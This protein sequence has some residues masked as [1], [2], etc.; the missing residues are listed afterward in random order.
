MEGRLVYMDGLAKVFSL[1][2]DALFPRSCVMCKEEGE[3]LCEVCAK[4]IEIPSWFVHQTEGS[5]CIFSRCSYKE[6]AVQKLLH[7]WKYQGDI[8]A[9]EWWKK[10]I[11][12]G[13]APEVFTHAVF[14]PVPLA[15]EAYAER[16]F[17]QAELLARALAQ[18]Y[19]GTC[20]VL[21]ERTPRKSQAKTAKEKRGSLRK[22]SPYAITAHA[23]DLK[24]R[25]EFPKKIILVD[26][27]TTT[28]STLLACA[29]ALTSVGVEQIAAC[30][31]AYGNVA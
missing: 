5:L 7:A 26:D 15:R 27:V 25:N 16:G 12:Q 1:V 23:K 2:W 17:N 29:D 20:G 30:T 8:L 10:W 4:E 22:E 21:L 24:K 9:G 31:L 19:Q 11:T 18:K 6:R 28:G 13:N 3:L 14:V